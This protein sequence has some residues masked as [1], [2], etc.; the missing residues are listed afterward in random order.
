MFHRFP[1]PLQKI[2]DIHRQTP[3]DRMETINP[4]AISPCE[5][6]IAVIIDAKNQAS[7]ET[8]N[9]TQGTRIATSS[10]ERNAI[11]GTGVAV[12]DTWYCNKSRT[13]H[14]V[15]YG[16]GKGRAEPVHRKANSDCNGFQSSAFTVDKQ[17]DHYLLEQPRCDT[18]YYPT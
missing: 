16:S 14:T 11:V 6:Q 8:A 9:A 12:H 10:S 1:S 5:E 15:K 13:D 18:S 7:T 2:A 3:T 17:I 4:S